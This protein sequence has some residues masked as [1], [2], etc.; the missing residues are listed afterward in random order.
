MK[1]SFCA[2]I[3]WPLFGFVF[4]ALKLELQTDLFKFENYLGHPPGRGEICLPRNFPPK[5]KIEVVVS[6]PDIHE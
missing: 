1:M 5:F 4:E 2:V 6:H 3:G